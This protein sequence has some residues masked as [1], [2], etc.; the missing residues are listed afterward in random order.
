MDIREASLPGAFDDAR[1]LIREYVA[2]LSD[3]GH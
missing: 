2:T 3:A 1:E